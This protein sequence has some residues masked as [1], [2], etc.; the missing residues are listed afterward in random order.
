MSSSN[1]DVKAILTDKT[2]IRAEVPI[3]LSE[4][5]SGMYL[6]TTAT[7]QSDGTFLASEVHVFSEDQ[8]GTGEG[9]R[10]LGSAPQS[11]ATMTNANVE[12]VED[13]AVKDIKGRLI[14]LKYKGGEV[15]VLVP[16]DIPLVKR[17]LGDRNSLKNGAEVSL[18]GTQSSGG[19]LEAT[20]VTVRTG[21]R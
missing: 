7:K 2:V 18:Q 19:A 12:H 4:I 16:P 20:Q 17:V 21:G 14:T 1:G 6:G 13:I 11:G 10:P 5:G 8:R 15:K 3:N 9:H